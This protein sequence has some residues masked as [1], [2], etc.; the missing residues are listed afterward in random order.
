MEYVYAHYYPFKAN[1]LVF[2]FK[3]KTFFL[4]HEQD[5]TNQVKQNTVL[6]PYSSL[7]PDPDLFVSEHAFIFCDS[8][9]RQYQL[10]NRPKRGHEQME[11]CSRSHPKCTQRMLGN[12]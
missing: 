1:P 9:L 6:V 2:M 4:K 8:M 10:V 7:M 11:K 5:V 12:K 3:N